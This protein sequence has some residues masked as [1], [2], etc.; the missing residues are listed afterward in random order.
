MN[1]MGRSVNVACSDAA[2]GQDGLV[3]PIAAAFEPLLGIPS[4][5]VTKG[6]GSF[7][8]MEF[9]NPELTVEPERNRS[10]RIA[11]AETLT[12]R[13]RY[14]VVQGAWHLWV[15]CCQWRLQ[16]SGVEIAHCE[17]DDLTINRALGVLNGQAL[18]GVHVDATNGG[19]QFE[20]DLGCVLRTHPAPDGSY[21]EEP[22]DQWMLYQPAGDILTVRGDGSYAIN[23][24]TAPESSS[25]WAPIPV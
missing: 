20:F 11:G 23:P 14:A 16:V 8:T 4:L 15:Y 7:V 21:A 25:T 18:S 5:S 19:S 9:G 2:I 13:T 17:S 10:L 1:V 12:V 6:H 3:N 22:V 24:R